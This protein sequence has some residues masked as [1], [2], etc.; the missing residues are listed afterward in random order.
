[1]SSDFGYINARVRGM[2]AKLLEPDFFTQALA[3]SDFKSFAAVLAQT[4]YK[5]DVEEAQARSDGLKV[6]DQAVARNFYRTTRSILNFSDGAA[7]EQIALVLRRYDLANLKAIARAKHADRGAEEIQAALLPAG[8]F[9]PAVLESL[10]S[11]AD[12]PAVAQALAATRHPLARAFRRAAAAYAQDGDLYAFELA[13]DRAYFAGLLASLKGWRVP[14][15]FVSYIKTEIDAT[16]LRTALKLRGE[17]ANGEDL[18][19]PGGRELPKATFDAIMADTS[20]GALSA[21]SSTA[22]ATVTEA[23]GLGEAEPL[24]RA[25][26]DAGARRAATADP[27][28]VGVVLRY[29]RRKE[30]E[31]AKLRLIARGKFYSVPQ[32]QLQKE[33]H[34]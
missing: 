27:L 25:E 34:G 1:M 2:T 17:E 15:A 13:L 19:V 28:G 3:E 12:L 20:K 9:K 5:Q 4:L 7:H 16:N 30:A 10:A 14:R 8:E 24:I 29:L 32:E 31:S 18:F 26:V 22:F 33:L 6:V 23:D 11:E 21:L